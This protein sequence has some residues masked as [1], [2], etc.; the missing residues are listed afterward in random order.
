MLVASL[1]FRPVP[2]L[3]VPTNIPITILFEQNYPIFQEKRLL[4]IKESDDRHRSFVINVPKQTLP[5]H[6][7]YAV[8]QVDMAISRENM[9][10]CSLATIQFNPLNSISNNNI[11]SFKVNDD[12]VMHTY[13]IGTLNAFPLFDGKLNLKVSCASGVNVNKVSLIVPHMVDEYWR[14]IK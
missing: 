11:L 4:P 9:V 14:R 5:E 8:W 10:D 2:V 12:G 13:N 1:N 3:N 7:D 6:P